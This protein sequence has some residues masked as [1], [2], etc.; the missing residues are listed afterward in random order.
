MN[1]LTR[2]QREMLAV[3]ADGEHV[4]DVA[5]RLFVTES[6]VKNTLESAYR[7]LGVH[8][9]IGAYRALGRLHLPEEER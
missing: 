8:S 5:R 2:R 4:R 7:R 3:L 6:T 9:A 1:E